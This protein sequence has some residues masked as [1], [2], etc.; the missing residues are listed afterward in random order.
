MDCR[1]LP[2]CSKTRGLGG[3]ALWRMQAQEVP[4]PADTCGSLVSPHVPPGYWNPKFSVGNCAEGLQPPEKWEM[5][6]NGGEM[7]GNRGKG[8]G[9]REKWGTID[10]SGWEA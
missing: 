1:G 10:R 4:G 8:V 7:G 9:N 6:A 3:H 5:R 2:G